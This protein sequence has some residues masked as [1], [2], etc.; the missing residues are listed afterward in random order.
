[1]AQRMKGWLLMNGRQYRVLHMVAILLSA[2]LL[3]SVEA[4]S[5]EIRLQVDRGED[6]GQHLGS[7]FE[8]GSEDGAFVLGAGFLDVYN[9]YCRSDRHAVH[10]F[11]RPTGAARAHTAAQL[12]RPGNLAGTYLFSRG[13]TLYATEP[14][15]RAWNPSKGQWETGA[16]KQR[17]QMQLGDGLL[18]YGDSQVAFNETLALGP[19]EQGRYSR[20]YYAQ[21][22]LFFYHTFW[23]EQS[24]YRLHTEDSKGFTK[25][26]A[27][28]WN[29]AQDTSVDLSKAVAITVPVVGENPFAWGQLRGDVLTCSNIGGIYAFDGAAWRTLL[30][31]ELKTSYQVYSMINFYDR[32]LLGQYPTGELFEFDGEE[33]RH[34]EGWPPTMPGVSGSA[35]EAQTITLYGGD[36][37]VGVWPW[38]ELWRYRPDAKQWDLVQRMFN[39]PALTD[40]TTHPYET[41]CA[42]L[43][44]V[45]NQW[46]QRVTSLVVQN[47]SLMISTSAKAPCA[48]EPKFDFLANDAWKEYGTVTQLTTPGHVSAPLAWT[49]GPTELRFIVN[50]T[51]MAIIQDGSVVAEA[52][53]KQLPLAVPADIAWG[54]GVYGAFGG[55]ALRGEVRADEAAIE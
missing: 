34:L 45:A 7:L 43:G 53:L 47:S 48:W 30:D 18:T 2:S 24:G 5:L 26:Y 3:G 4:F 35:R 17:G 42:A 10:F 39:R 51:R 8:T 37:F 55:S 19:P 13:D 14:E 27:C 11:I 23:A 44:G 15:V 32:L 28:P 31:G 38:G 33:V 29:P 1:M 6:L 21:G 49:D 40:K 12:P 25:L 41:E 16:V 54:T 52:P 36:L 20:F 9:T 46:G 22:H 50:D